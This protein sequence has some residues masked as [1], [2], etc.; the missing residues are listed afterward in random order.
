MYDNR[1]NGSAPSDREECGKYLWWLWEIGAT[2]EG[3]HWYVEERAKYHDHGSMA[4][5]YPSDDVEAFV[6]SGSAVFDK[7]CVEALRP[8]TKPPRYVGDIYAHGDEGEDALRDL[9]FK[10]DAQGMLWVW[11]LPDPVN[12]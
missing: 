12:P 3:I 8:T 9:R 1:L 11:N 10:A 4:S 5:E 7:Y 6:N 2:L